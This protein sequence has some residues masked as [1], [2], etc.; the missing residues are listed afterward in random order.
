MGFSRAYR[1]ALMF[2]FSLANRLTSNHGDN[3]L[4]RPTVRATANLKVNRAGEYHATGSDQDLWETP[5]SDRRRLCV[6]AFLV[7]GSD[8]QVRLALG[9]RPGRPLDE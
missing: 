6:L 1:G 9:K 8:A 2:I 7:T 3:V 5:M 4:C